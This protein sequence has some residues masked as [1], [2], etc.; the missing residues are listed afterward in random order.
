MIKL[1]R[2]MVVLGVL[3]LGLGAIGPALATEAKDPKSM[4]AMDV[5]ISC[6][7]ENWNK[8]ILSLFQ[9]KH[10]VK[11]DPRTPGCQTCHGMSAKHLESP[12]NPPDVKYT[13]S[14]TNTVEERNEKCLSCHKGGARMQWEGSTHNVNGLACATCHDIHR[15]QQRVLSKATQPEVC[16]SCHK[17]QRAEFNKSTH[18]PL[19]EGKMACSDCHNPHGTTGTKLLLKDSVVETCTTCHAEKRGPFLW[20]HPPAAD[21]CTNCHAQHGSNHRPLLKTRP[22]ML[23]QQCHDFTQHPGSAYSAAQIP[24]GAGTPAQQLLLRGCV[25]CHSQIHGTNHPSGPRLTR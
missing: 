14:S 25:N 24:G 16:F 21:S 3:A 13:K 22:P 11:G 12:A 9:T 18:M 4:E 15:P 1:L 2:K 10:G 17:L 20:E 8:P 19:R 5:C 7:N 6:H 23:C